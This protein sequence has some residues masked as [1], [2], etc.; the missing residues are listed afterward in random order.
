MDNFVPEHCEYTDD[1]CDL[2]PSCLHCPLSRCRYDQPGKQTGKQLRNRE[3][4]RRYKDGMGVRELAQRFA[5]SKRT[6]YR[7]IAG[8]NG[9]AQRE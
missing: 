3:M 1:G 5:V 2:F 7:V 4:M 9:E 6:V 8:S